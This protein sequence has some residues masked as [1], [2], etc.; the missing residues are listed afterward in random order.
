MS[1]EEVVSFTTISWRNACFENDED[2]VGLT[3]VAA[4]LCIVAGGRACGSPPG[5][6]ANEL[7][8]WE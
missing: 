8:T 4:G 1:D 6:A 2:K 3:R 7:A 5:A